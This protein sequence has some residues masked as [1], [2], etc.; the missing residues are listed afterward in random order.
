MPEHIT[1]GTKEMARGITRYNKG[2]YKDALE[3]F[4]RAHELFVAADQLSGVAMSL[5]NMGNVYRA[6]G[7]IDSA[8]L[9][10]DESLAIYS[11]IGDP[12][13]GV[14]VLCN[15]AAAL[16]DGGRLEK[17][18]T[19]LNT[20]EKMAEK[21]RISFGP[22]LSNR[23]ILL[24]KKA[25]YKN[26]EELLQM[27]LA[28]TDPENLSEFATVNFALGNLM[29]ETQRYEKAMDFFKTALKADRLSGGN[30]NIADDLAALGSDCLK[31]GEDELAGN[32]FKRSVEI[33]ALLG[34][35]KNAQN[36][37]EKLEKV[38]EKTG[39]DLS[40]TKHF[41]NR[42]LEGKALGSLCD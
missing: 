17:A 13:G 21:N 19:V 37:M 1:A 41:V 25:Q 4:L 40:I 38:S 23:G 20:A 18:E 10:F 11:D 22:L 35:H 2:C 7:D 3:Y 8:L 12:L 28:N 39:M 6:T 9:F 42:W 34:N 24:I 5:N 31:L 16:I 15:K 30:K 26:A 27:V 29:V 14:Q 36:I 32:F 33:Y